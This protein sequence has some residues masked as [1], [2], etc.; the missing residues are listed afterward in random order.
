MISLD[1]A[2]NAIYLIAALVSAAF[3]VVENAIFT[4]DLVYD[5]PTADRV[6][7]SKRLK[8][9]QHQGRN[10]IALGW[11]PLY[12]RMVLRIGQLAR[13]RL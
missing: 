7:L 12:S 3:W 9:A 6:V 10:A 13:I 11:L 1:N 8:I 5:R 4:P 2:R